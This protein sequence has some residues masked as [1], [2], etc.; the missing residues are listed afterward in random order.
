MARKPWFVVM[1]PEQA[2]QPGSNWVRVGASSRGKVSAMPVAWE[3]WATIIGF[4]VLLVVVPLLIWVNGVAGGRLDL[5][6]GIVLT[7]VALALLIGGFAWLI[8][9]R[10][11]T[12]P[13]SG[14]P[15][16]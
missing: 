5:V 9:T 7:I 4:I 13:P 3:G 15:P 8:R 10:S 6:E 12:L 2:N 11:T 1:R 14:Y 16:T